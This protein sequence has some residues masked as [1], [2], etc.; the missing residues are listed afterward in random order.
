M[1]QT[2]I[3][4]PR[5]PPEKIKKKKSVAHKNVDFCDICLEFGSLIC[6]DLCPRSFHPKCIKINEN[7]SKFNC[8]DCA[9]GK[10]PMYGDIVWSHVPGYRWW[11]AI[12]LPD[13]V[14]PEIILGSRRNKRDFCLR[15]FGS[16]DYYWFPSENVLPYDAYTQMAGNFIR[17][18]IKFENAITEANNTMELKRKL[19]VLP[20]NLWKKTISNRVVTPVALKKR[21]IGDISVCKCSPEDENPCGKS[22][23]CI[24]R[25]LFYECN[26]SLCPA[27]EKCQNQAMQKRNY[28]KLST[29]KTLT[30]GTGVETTNS[31][32]RGDFIIEYV[33]EII[34][35]TEFNQRLSQK[36][37]NYDKNF[38][39][40]SLTSNL[41][42]DAEFYG[43]IARFFN[44]S[45]E[46]NCETRKI[47]MNGNTR[48]GLFS[49]QIIEEVRCYCNTFL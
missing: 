7:T 5:H 37:A 27:G 45:C 21:K 25:D 17:F 6:C 4:C 43:N 11:P 36:V 34:N 16:Y 49:K 28:A 41:Y 22:S 24:N 33:G 31:L 3:I 38:Y 12:I 44:H 48:I 9:K 30:R 1:S 2:Q 19:D 35:T 32:E 40:M 29:V 42:I 13:I 39:I 46:P 20:E 26:K 18:N 15:F 47:M 23:R 10:M 8:K 14:V